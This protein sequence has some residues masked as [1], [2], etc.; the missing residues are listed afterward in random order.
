MKI[1]CFQIAMISAIIF[2]TSLRI[3]AHCE[4]PC[5][6]YDDK[7]RVGMIAEH[8]STIEKAMK[9][10]VTIQGAKSLD[11]NQLVRW[12]TT[13]DKHADEIQHIV[14]QYFMTQRIKPDS[15][16]Y[17]EKLVLLHKMLIDAMKCKQTTDTAFTESLHNL[18][19]KF[20][21]LYFE[22]SKK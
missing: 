17:Q 22:E 14:S 18:L 16:K 5:G 11:Y 7:A 20:Q 19:D 4:V 1:R 21:K 10:I 12:I 6:I 9:E 15:D 13:K 2:V 3:F 8:I